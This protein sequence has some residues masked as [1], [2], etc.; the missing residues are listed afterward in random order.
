MWNTTGPAA[1]KFW[2]APYDTIRLDAKY[3][4]QK[5]PSEMNEM[6][7]I[8]TFLISNENKGFINP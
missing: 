1:F 4:E 5:I 6:L 7:S 2:T 3:R 8:T